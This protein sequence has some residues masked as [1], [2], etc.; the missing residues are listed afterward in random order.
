MTTETQL[1]GLPSQATA[2]LTDDD[3]LVVAFA[4]IGAPGV[5]GRNGQHVFLIRAAISDSV[6]PAARLLHFSGLGGVR[7]LATY[8]KPVATIP[9][10]I[11]LVWDRTANVGLASNDSVYAMTSDDG[12]AT[13]Q[14][15]EKLPLPFNAASLAQASDAKGNVHIVVTTSKALGATSSALYHAALINAKWTSLEPAFTDSV[16]S[17]PT[18]SSIGR[19]TLL[20]AWGIGRPAK[21]GWPGAVAPVTKYSLIVSA[22][23]GER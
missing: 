10:A 13:W 21:S 22:C 18:L 16:A 12:G 6:L 2:Q 15:P 14:A 7:W 20:L 5:R 4:G 9:R 11:T 17:T 23:P 8:T 3:S 1:P 19:N